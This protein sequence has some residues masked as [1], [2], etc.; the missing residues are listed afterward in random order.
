MVLSLFKLYE[1][2]MRL[3]STCDTPNEYGIGVFAWNGNKWSCIYTTIHWEWHLLLD[4]FMQLFHVYIVRIYV[5]SLY[6]IVCLIYEQGKI[7]I[8]C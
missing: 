3:C 4:P 2:W 7:L 5:S 8:K 1:C 6:V